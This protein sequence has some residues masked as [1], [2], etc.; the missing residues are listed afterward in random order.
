MI[1]TRL[2]RRRGTVPH[3]A[4][5]PAALLLVLA[6]AVALPA[7]VHGQAPLSTETAEASERTAPTPEGTEAAAQNSGADPEVDNECHPPSTQQWVLIGVGTLAIF[8][9]CFFL[10]VRLVQRAFIHRDKNA[11]LG[12]HFGISITFLVGS[13]GMTALAYLIT[14]CLHRQF[15]LWLCF[16]LA[17]WAIHGLYTLI[18]VRNE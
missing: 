1:E 6:A 13:L 5:L 14:G 16:P 9:V 8:V 10:L 2:V 7:R 3:R 17:L 4:A 11:T 15:V 18:V 12:R